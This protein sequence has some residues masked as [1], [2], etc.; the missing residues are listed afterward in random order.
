MN[1]EETLAVT[2]IIYKD[3]EPY[4]YLI[5]RHKDG[6]GL[7]EQWTI[8]GGT[9]EVKD[10]VRRPST[11]ISDYFSGEIERLIGTH[12]DESLHVA[13]DDIEYLYDPAEDH[14]EEP[15]SVLS[16]Y[17][18]YV[19]GTPEYGKE[20]EAVWTTIENLVHYDVAEDIRTELVLVDEILRTKNELRAVKKAIREENH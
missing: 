18:K 16:Y 13:V 20:L 1:P 10:F 11:N 19:A 6:S 2:G 5:V 8:P 9:L 17:A 3:T 4:Q 15:L 7:V 14:N 12:I